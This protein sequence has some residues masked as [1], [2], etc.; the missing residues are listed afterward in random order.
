MREADDLL[1][2]HQPRVDDHVD[3]GLLEDRD[4]DRIDDDRHGERDAV[5]LGQ[6]RGVEVP[7]VGRHHE[8]GRFRTADSLA[9]EKVGVHP[10]RV[11]D[12]RGRQQLGNSACALAVRLDDA[13]RGVLAEQDLGDPDAGVAGAEEDDVRDTVASLREDLAPDPYRPRRADH[14]HAVTR[15]DRLVTAGH[16]HPVSPDDGCHLRVDRDLRILQLPPDRLSRRRALRYVE[17][18]HQHLALGE[19]IRLACRRDADDPGDRVRRLELG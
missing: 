19:D 11:E 6:R 9:L 12:T 8:D 7:L 13:D 15:L 3:P 10:A 17:L 4:R 1:G 2:G 18:D 5:E 16:D 14:D